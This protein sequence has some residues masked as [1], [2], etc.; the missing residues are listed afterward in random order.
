MLLTRFCFV[1]FT[2]LS[3]ALLIGQTLPATPTPPAAVS[4]LVPGSAVQALASPEKAAIADAL[5]RYFKG[6][7]TIDPDLVASAI[8]PEATIAGGVG[9]P[10]VESASYA[11]ILDQFRKS[12]GTMTPPSVKADR[13]LT[14]LF[15]RGEMATAFVRMTYL[16]PTRGAGIP[17]DYAFQFYKTGGRWTIVSVLNHAGQYAG[18]TDDTTL[19]AMGIRRGMTIGEIGAGSGRVTLALA[20][21]VGD[22]GKVY[23]NDID[24]KPLA[25]LRAICERRGVTNVETIVSKTDDPMFP[26]DSLDL[27]IMAIVYHHL[28]QPVALLETLASSLKPGATVVIVDPAYDRTGDKDSDRPTTRERVESEAARAGYELIA[29]NASLPRDNIF[30]LRRKVDGPAA[31]V[32]VTTTPWTPPREGSDRTAV[33]ATIDTWWKGHDADDAVLLDSAMAPGTRSWFVHEGALQFL[34]YAQEIERIRSGKRR[35]ASRPLPGETRT[36]V[37]FKQE[38]ASAVVTMLV[39]IPRNGATSR[40]FTTFQLYKADDR[41]QIVNVAG[42]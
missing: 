32:K 33:L 27:A 3:P 5:E 16:P 2:L 41:W 26:S 17:I 30:I 15:L 4:L 10:A 11:Q 37:D 22:R 14:A 13:T 40:S 6:F 12:R 18:E 1:A 7:D 29:F 28:E 35:P 19:D 21:R 38:G 39:E 24:S 25:K 34:P 20:R 23:A 42:T 8:H 31:V 36:V 9:Q